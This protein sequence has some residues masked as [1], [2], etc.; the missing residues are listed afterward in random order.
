MFPT[1]F[2]LKAAQSQ[3]VLPVFDDIKRCDSVSYCALRR[4]IWTILYTREDH[5][6]QYLIIFFRKW[7]IVDCLNTMGFVNDVLSLNRVL[8]SNIPHL[9][10][11][12]TMENGPGFESG[13]RSEKGDVWKASTGA[14]VPVSVHLPFF[15]LHKPTITKNQVNGFWIIEK[16]TRKFIQGGPS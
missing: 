4:L 5:R 2:L 6:M 11:H 7:P 10:K 16:W 15:K 14:Y 3:P 9:D 13:E 12:F 1:A 8:G